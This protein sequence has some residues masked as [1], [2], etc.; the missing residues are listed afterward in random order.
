[1]EKA[2]VISPEIPPA[3]EIMAEVK[4]EVKEATAEMVEKLLPATKRR[5]WYYWTS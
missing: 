3:E 5:A 2:K 1:M 4:E